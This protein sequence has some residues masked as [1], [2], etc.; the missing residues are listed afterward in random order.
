MFADYSVAGWRSG[1][2]IPVLESPTDNE[3]YNN[4]GKPYNGNC[5]NG[6][7][8]GYRVHRVYVHTPDGSTHELRDTDEPYIAYGV[9]HNGIFY[10]VDGSRL[11]Y[12]SSTSTLWMPDGSRYILGSTTTQFIDRN[13]NILNYDNGTQ[14]WTDTMGPNVGRPPG[15]GP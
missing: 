4:N 14:T 7:S 1:L 6:N 12:V 9:S 11:K 2:D 15:F 13:G 10:A 5:N 3:I 8:N